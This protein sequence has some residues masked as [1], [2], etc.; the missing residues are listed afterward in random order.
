MWTE[1]Q[2]KRLNQSFYLDPGN[3]LRYRR[4]TYQS[5]LYDRGRNLGYCRMFLVF[6]WRKMFQL[7][8]DES[9]CFL[10]NT[11]ISSNLLWG[12]VVIFQWQILS[13]F[14][15]DAKILIGCWLPE[16]QGLQAVWNGGSWS[17]HIY[18]LEFSAKSPR[19]CRLVT[20]RTL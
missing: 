14:V 3:L 2:A 17:F 20:R 16:G 4:P 19:S 8:K 6:H 11:S 15:W 12:A 7:E 9:R 13:P 5:C 18:T 10:K 1:F